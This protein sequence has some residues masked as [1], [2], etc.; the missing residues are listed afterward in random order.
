MV[1]TARSLP[2]GLREIFE[3]HS[4]ERTRSANP[5][6]WLE[7]G[8]YAGRTRGCHAWKG[9]GAMPKATPWN[10]P[11]PPALRAL[12]DAGGDEPRCAVAGQGYMWALGL[13]DA[14][15]LRRGLAGHDRVAACRVGWQAN[16]ARARYRRGRVGKD[17]QRLRLLMEGTA[18]GGPAPQPGC[19][20][21]P[22]R[23][24]GRS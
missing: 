8:A 10:G 5:R 14:P 3:R 19:A 20:P 7:A 4:P 18:V 21:R 12:G 17:V 16:G 22:P 23:Q 24:R 13:H 2:G 11:I 9:K 1:A 15:T 6:H